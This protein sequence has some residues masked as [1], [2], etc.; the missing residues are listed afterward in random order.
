MNVNY[1]NIKNHSLLLVLLL[2][3]STCISQNLY[4]VEYNLTLN[5]PFSGSEVTFVQYEIRFT[6]GI[7]SYLYYF[8]GVPTNESNTLTR[9]AIVN[10]S[11]NPD[12]IN[13]QALAFGAFGTPCDLPSQTDR[14]YNSSTDISFLPL[15]DFNCAIPSGNG[16]SLIMA[17]IDGL[18]VLNTS[19]GNNQL[20]NCEPRTIRTL[21]SSLFSMSYKVEYQIEPNTTNW[22]TLLP[23]ARRSP[24]FEIEASD[25]AGLSSSNPILRL[26][27]S[28]DES[29]TEDSM[30]ILTLNFV[31]CSPNII[32]VSTTNTTCSYTED[33]A[34]TIIFEEN[35]DGDTL[36]NIGVFSPGPDGIFDG[37]DIFI[38]AAP[39]IVINGNQY[40][41]PNA[42]SPGRYRMIY[43]TNGSNSDERSPEFTITTPPPLDYEVII[44]SEISCFDEE[45]G[46]IRINIDPDNIGSIGTPGYYY[47]RSD[48]PGT[49]HFFNSTTTTIDNIGTDT[50]T[51][52]V[53]DSND[54]TERN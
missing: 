13:F 31:E 16:T 5:S 22:T 41:F 44:E 10:L 53:F 29:N 49:Q 45:N 40:T 17:R 54:C 28:Y 21:N 26:R 23:Y 48:D 32:G 3:A 42:L 8:D 39:D 12:T 37:N 24:D 51:I 43:Q 11:F 46:S 33:G 36:S 2:I 9:D 6:S 19:Q 50:I 35:L 4:K 14:P 18:E 7:D 1:K 15:A 38:D 52:R 25:F 34:F 20:F 30:Q 27:V 47:T